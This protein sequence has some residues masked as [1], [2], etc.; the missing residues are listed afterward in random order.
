MIEKKACFD[1]MNNCFHVSAGYFSTPFSRLIGANKAKI[2]PR[3]V[4]EY[5]LNPNHPVGGSKAKVFDSALGFNQS[6][7]DDLLRQLQRGV[8]ENSPIAGK[9]DKFGSRFTVDIPVTGP[10][11]SGFVSTGWIYKPGSNT[12]ELTTLF[13]K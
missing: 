9:V 11:G 1:P 13:V 4:T 2:D 7:A 12:P 8:M 10:R 5:A 6:N 3:K